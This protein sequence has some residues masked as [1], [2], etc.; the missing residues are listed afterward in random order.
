MTG[1]GI[2]AQLVFDG[3]ETVRIPPQM[4]TPREDQ[5]LGTAAERLSELAGRVCYDSLGKGRPSFSTPESQGYHDHIA[6]VG[7]GSVWEHFNFTVEIPVGTSN[8]HSNDEWSV[9]NRRMLI[10]FCCCN[11]PGVLALMADH[12]EAIRITVNLRAVLEWLS[13][14]ESLYGYVGPVEMQMASMLH[15]LGHTLAPHIVPDVPRFEGMVQSRPGRASELVFDELDQAK[16]VPPI[17]DHERWVSMYL[18]GSRGLSHELVR[19][20]DFTAISQRST[21]YVDESEGD[22]VIHPLDR[23]YVADAP[24]EEAIAFDRMRHATI[25]GCRQHYDHVVS[26]LEPWLLSRGVDKA[27]A[28]KQAR[29]AARGYLG[30]ALGTELIFSANVAQWKWMLRQRASAAADAEIR[31]LF[32]KVLPELHASR[33][34]ESFADWRLVPSPDGVGQVAIEE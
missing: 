23:A 1:N 3:G 22:W 11:R 5:M 10:A 27:T 7:H 12:P 18:T 24:E 30:N 21:R 26:R 32:C 8:M 33:Y 31:E 28:R 29:G 34:L 2:H 9:E 4:G 17:S 15:R 20:G 13:W 25:T 16:I 14:S 19:H 6:Q